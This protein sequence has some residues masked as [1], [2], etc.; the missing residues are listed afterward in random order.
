MKKLYIILAA[1]MLSACASQ[2]GASSEQKQ[3]SDHTTI[4]AVSAAEEAETVTLTADVLSYDGSSITVSSEGKEY[5]LDLS[6]CE[7]S[8]VLN[9]DTFPDITGRIINNPFGIKTSVILKCDPAFTKA[10]WCDAVSPNGSISAP[11][12]KTGKPENEL[13]TDSW[14]VFGKGCYSVYDFEYFEMT[15]KGEYHGSGRIDLSACGLFS[16]PE[17]SEGDCFNVQCFKFKDEDCF[18]GLMTYSLFESK[19]ETKDKDGNVISV[20]RTYFGD[21]GEMPVFFGTVTDVDT[22]NC[23]VTVKL[24]SGA[25]CTLTPS[26]TVGCHSL[27]VGDKVAARFTDQINYPDDPKQTDFDFAVIEKTDGLSAELVSIVGGEIYAADGDRKI[28]VISDNILD[29]ET[30]K[31]V[32]DKNLYSKI[33]IE[34]GDISYAISPKGSEITYVYYASSVKLER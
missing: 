30:L 2:E 6:E 10:Y 25:V 21:P 26:V 22:E 20:S 16:A 27:S 12:P 15:K 5:A 1:L 3:T 9:S 17:F 23:K 29:A 8:S 19:E 32:A 34:H 14:S 4:S 31:P 13:P 18:L 7:Y 33:G 24:G 11:V 28:T